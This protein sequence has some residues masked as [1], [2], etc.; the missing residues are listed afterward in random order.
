MAFG[1]VIR[2]YDGAKVFEPSFATR[3]ELPVYSS[4]V[5]A[6]FPSPADDYMDGK[7]DLNEH[8]VKRSAATFIVTVEGHSMIDAGI[9]DGDLLIVDRSIEAKDKSIILACLGGEFTVK[10]LRVING[11]PW[12]YPENPRYHP[13]EIKEDFDFEIFG[14]VMHSIHNHLLSR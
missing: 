3:L 11:Q 12:L 5:P 6:G 13:M 8:L 4:K 2:I 14:V 1:N 10:R 7:L 9:F